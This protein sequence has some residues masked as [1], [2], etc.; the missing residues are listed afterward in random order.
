MVILEYTCFGVIEN[1][2]LE[3]IRPI[4]SSSYF[5]IIIIIIGIIIRII[6]VRLARYWQS[7]VASLLARHQFQHWSEIDP[8]FDT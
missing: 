7:L 5:I 8:Y 1:Y 3:Y 6:V 2:L 4:R